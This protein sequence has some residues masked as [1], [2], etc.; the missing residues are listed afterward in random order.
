MIHTAFYLY[1]LI[2][3]FH[4][5]HVIFIAKHDDK[6]TNIELIQEHYIHV[7]I[8]FSYYLSSNV[9]NS[10]Q[11]GRKLYEISWYVASAAMYVTLSNSPRSRTGRV[12]SS[13][14][15]IYLRPHQK[16]SALA[17]SRAVPVH[18]AYSSLENSLGFFIP[19]VFVFTCCRR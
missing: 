14:S 5:Q 17:H 2:R 16:P 19:L 13:P 9:T 8:H 12:E 1:V 6:L 15:A 4:K 11:N 7:N 3:I 18:R 10:T